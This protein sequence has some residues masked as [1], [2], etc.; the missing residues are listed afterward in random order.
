[1]PKF[2]S[3]HIVTT[4]NC[5]KLI[6]WLMS[7]FQSELLLLYSVYFLFVHFCWF[8]FVVVVYKSPKWRSFL[9]TGQGILPKSTSCA[10]LILPWATNHSFLSRLQFQS[11]L[12]FVLWSSL[13]SPDS[14]LGSPGGQAILADG[15]VLKSTPVNSS[16]GEGLCD[17]GVA[18]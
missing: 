7:F 1:M 3:K 6:R 11:I 16:A 10:D 13:A 12:V 17:E 9:S 8:F 4:H 2:P 15:H 14:F 18:Q 5:F